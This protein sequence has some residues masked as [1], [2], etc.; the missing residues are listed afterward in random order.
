MSCAP[1]VSSP[2]DVV[3]EMLEVA[4]ASKDDVL[5]DLGCG[6]GRIL[7]TVVKDFGIKAAVGYEI[8]ADLFKQASGEV[9]KLKLFERVHIFNKDFFQADLKHATMITL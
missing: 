7:T 8:R 1:F 3:K 5:C 2:H 4:R 6:D 9:D